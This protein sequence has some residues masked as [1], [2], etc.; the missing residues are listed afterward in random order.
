MFW[1]AGA[2]LAA[3]YLG[4]ALTRLPVVNID[5][6]SAAFTGAVLMVLF[7]VLSFDEAVE[8]IDFHTIALL[9]GM[10]MLVVVLGRGGFFTYLAERL[11]AV[12]TTPSR[13]LV[14]VVAVTGLLSAFLVNDA[15]VLLFTPVVVR[16]C[17]LVRVNPVPYLI[18][19]AMSSNAGST[20]TIVGNPQNMLIGIGSGIS[21]TR[22]FLLLAPVALLGCVAVALVVWWLYRRELRASPFVG[23][24]S[25]LKTGVP[26]S[27]HVLRRSVPILVATVIALF[28]SSTLNVSIS[29]IALVA[30]TVVMLTSRVRPSEVIRG[31]DWV[32]LLFFA[33]LFV[34][35]GGANQAGVLDGLL[36]RISITPDLKGILSL[37]LVSTA[38]SQVVS[39]VPLTML[40]IPIIKGVPGQV[41]WISLAA[42]ATLGGNVTII[43]AVANIIVAEVAAREG[44]TL[45]FREFLRVGLLVTPLTIALSVGVLALEWWYG[46]LT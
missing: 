33:G 18:A 36:G 41:L 15:V 30:G 6:P 1:T 7:G 3:T 29:V 28:L 11:L 12:G 40:V 34:V 42:G 20:A 46:F 2:I 21:F 31:V 13:L 37:H 4:I 38:V 16:A 5:R 17:R 35:I 10:M 22:F 39:N 26:D 24:L 9:L 45:S 32:L 8:A 44:V 27:S 23:D 14:V 43:G 25:A 19:E